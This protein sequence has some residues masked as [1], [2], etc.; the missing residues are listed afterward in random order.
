[1]SLLLNS[2]RYRSC[3][4]TTR[5]HY[6]KQVNGIVYWCT[7]KMHAYSLEASIISHI[8]QDISLP[9]Q[10]AHYEQAFRINRKNNY[11]ASLHW[12]T[13]TRSFRYHRHYKNYG[14]NLKY[15]HTFPYFTFIIGYIHH[16]YSIHAFTG[17][18]KSHN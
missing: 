12:M 15:T 3:T 4:V 14:N 8:T 1:M 17:L 7:G 13:F 16:R 18:D 10:Y 9:A 2:A 6:K 5:K 11:V